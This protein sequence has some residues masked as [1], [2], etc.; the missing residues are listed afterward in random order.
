MCER[1]GAKREREKEREG[2]REGK[3]RKGNLITGTFLVLEGVN[4]GGREY[5]LSTDRCDKECC[6]GG[7]EQEIRNEGGGEVKYQIPPNGVEIKWRGRS[8]LPSYAIASWDG[9]LKE[10]RTRRVPAMQKQ[11]LECGL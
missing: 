9:K 3:R 1:E 10:E 5:V 8:H 2:G 11:G 7:K 6:V 4:V